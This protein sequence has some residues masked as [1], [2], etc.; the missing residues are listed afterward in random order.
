MDT[1]IL[2]NLTLFIFNDQINL[3]SKKY[4]RNRKIKDFIFN[5]LI[6]KKNNNSFE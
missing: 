3:Y 1:I 5:R 6:E 4:S 2:N